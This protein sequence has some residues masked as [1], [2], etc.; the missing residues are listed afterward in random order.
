MAFVVAHRGLSA[1]APEN[2]FDSFDLAISNGIKHIEF[3]VQLSKDNEVVIIH[4]DTVDRTSN[5]SGSVNEKTLKELKNLD[6]GSWFSEK[7]KCS[8]IPTFQ[9]LLDKYRDINLVVEIKGKEPELVSKVMEI[10]SNNKY[11]K[12]KIYKSKTTNPKI[13]FCSFLPNQLI[14]LRLDYQDLVI[15]FLVKEINDEI[16]NFAL[17]YNLDGIFPYFKLINE[18]IIKKLKGDKFLVSSWGFNNIE[19]SKLFLHLDIDGVTVDWPN[20]I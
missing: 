12:D 15:G 18:K 8:K 19:E 10:I 3:D 7:F 13:I 14:K 16:L 1:E 6:F 17:K 11:W 5:G 9:E 4:D 2:T 20:R